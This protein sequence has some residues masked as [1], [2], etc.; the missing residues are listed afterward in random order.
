MAKAGGGGGRGG[1]GGGGRS[2]DVAS[3]IR[4]K[5]KKVGEA[6][7]GVTP[8]ANR[9]GT[10]IYFGIGGKR[11]S[12]YAMGE[13][14]YNAETGKWYGSPRLVGMVARAYGIPT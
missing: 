9:S 8:R 12:G 3:A 13:V 2:S 11:K 5:S 7:W 10:R 6:G 1:G 14:T 4:G